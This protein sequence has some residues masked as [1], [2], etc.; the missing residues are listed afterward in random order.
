MFFKNYS[1]YSRPVKPI[2]VKINTQEN[3]PFGEYFFKEIHEENIRKTK[4]EMDLRL[5]E[6]L[7]THGECQ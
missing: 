4:R 1:V 7:K 6:Y 2:E 3:I 5:K